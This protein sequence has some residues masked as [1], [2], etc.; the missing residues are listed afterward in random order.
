MNESCHMWMR[1]VTYE[2]VMSH[3]NELCH[4]W[5]SHVT[6]ESYPLF[7]EINLNPKPETR[8]TDRHDPHMWHDSFKRDIAHGHDNQTGRYSTREKHRAPLQHTLQHTLQHA[9]QHTLQHALQYTLQHTLHHTATHLQ[10]TAGRHYASWNTKRHCNTRRNTCCNAHCNLR[11]NIRCNTLQHT[12]NTLQHTCNTL[13]GGIMRVKNK[14]LLHRLVAA[15]AKWPL[16]VYT[17]R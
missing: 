7:D 4:I 5:M 6:Y 13:Q 3:M 9:L 15:H 8:L 2:W 14:K 16:Q 10:L 12:C 1:H 11:C 17:S